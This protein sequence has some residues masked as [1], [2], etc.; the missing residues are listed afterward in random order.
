MID[1]RNTDQAFPGSHSQSLLA[2]AVESKRPDGRHRLPPKPAGIGTIV[3]T[4]HLRDA[5][6]TTFSSGLLCGPLLTFCP[7]L[8]RNA[9][10]GDAGQFSL[11]VSAFGFGGL[12]GA[13]ALLALSPTLDRRRISSWFAAGF[14]LTLIMAAL[15][16]WFW[17]LVALLVAAGIAMSVTNTSTNTIV[18][19]A[20]S[21]QLRGKA[22]SLYMLAMRGSI[23]LGSLA[24]GGACPL[25]G[26]L[27][28]AKVRSQ[29]PC[30]KQCPLHQP[31]SKRQ[32]A[33]E[34]RRFNEKHIARQGFK[35]TF[36][37]AAN[38]KTL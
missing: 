31:R 34:I 12:I 17:S 15:V 26:F 18:Q 38:D 25:G 6:L 2:S 3:R 8:V 13:V 20:A 19:T 21:A 36:C 22:V 23:A 29:I 16:P 28:E 27:E 32:V 33:R 37:G 5:L 24:T 30:I 9:F 1:Q 14:G 11:S 10:H 35:H 7:V 4:P